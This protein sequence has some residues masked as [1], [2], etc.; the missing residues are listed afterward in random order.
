[1]STYW[2]SLNTFSSLELVLLAGELGTLDTF[3][4][5]AAHVRLPGVALLLLH[6]G[7]LPY[8]LLIHNLCRCASL[9]TGTH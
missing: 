1:M 3:L 2:D 5:L 8:G 9:A 6:V 7:V 4:K